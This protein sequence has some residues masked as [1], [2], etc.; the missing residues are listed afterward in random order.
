MS[1]SMWF[2]ESVAQ[3]K[4]ME[5]GT[6]GVVEPLNTT[7]K[8]LRRARGMR[9]TD[10][11]KHELL[12]QF[13]KRFRGHVDQQLLHDAVRHGDGRSLTLRPSLIH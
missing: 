6:F 4:R 1:T 3:K 10:L 11:A 9:D 5:V 7:I 8:S 12:H 2:R 13:S